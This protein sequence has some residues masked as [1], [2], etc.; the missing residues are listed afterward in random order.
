MSNQWHSILAALVIGLASDAAA[1][2][3]FDF[4]TGTPSH[5][6]NT[7]PIDWT[8]DGLTASFLVGSGGFSIQTIGSMGSGT[9]LSLFSGQFLSSAANG[10]VDVLDIKFSQPLSS[11]SFD[12]A[13]DNHAPNETP[14]D[15][16]LTAY[17]SSSSVGSTTARGAFSDPDANPHNTL[18]MGTLSNYSPGTPFDE[19]KLQI[20]AG[21]TAPGFLIDNLSVTPVPE[22]AT[23]AI[24]GLLLLGLAPWLRR[25]QAQS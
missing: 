13:T 19:I 7:L 20:K 17:F 12:F 1:A 22:P 5:A 14:S 11:L 21:G 9:V 15:L 16:Q 23:A 25:R 2:V 8:T 10:P 6:G 3:M 24:A 4:D 18:P